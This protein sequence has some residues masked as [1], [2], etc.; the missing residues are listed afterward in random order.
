MK[1]SV[2][3]AL[4][5]LSIALI[6]CFPPNIAAEKPYYSQYKL[7]ISLLNQLQKQHPKESVFYSSHSVYQTLLMAYVGAGGETKKEIERALHLT[8]DESDIENM[9]KF[10]AER[11]NRFQNQS[12]E[13]ASAN[14]F[15]VSSC[16]KI[17]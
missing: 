13:F 6:S 10:Q 14:K 12:I 7:A 5:L 1:K 15:Y 9:H 8:E 2:M 16:M 4:A 11:S 17:R 3:A